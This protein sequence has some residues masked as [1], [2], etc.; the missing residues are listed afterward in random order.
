MIERQRRHQRISEILTRN[1]IHNQDQLRDLLATEDIAVTQAT[2]SRDLRD[3][4]AI[5]NTDGYRLPTIDRN[6]DAR[7]QALRRVL[8]AGVLAVQRSGTLVVIAT[9]PAGADTVAALLDST[10]LPAVLGVVAH[11]DTVLVATPAAAAA[12]ELARVLTGYAGLR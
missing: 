10:A 7:T 4:G 8:T 6:G 12:R 11:R 9:R 2:L 1:E 5:K 3:I